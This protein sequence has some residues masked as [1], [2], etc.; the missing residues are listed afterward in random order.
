MI[1][2]NINLAI[3]HVLQDATLMQTNFHIAALVS[4]TSMK[5]SS[6]KGHD[7]QNPLRVSVPCQM[8]AH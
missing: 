4:T 2:W 6:L 8:S 7:V 3:V 5:G 1:Y